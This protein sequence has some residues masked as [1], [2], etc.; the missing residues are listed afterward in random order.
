MR[1]NEG[2]E[3]DTA[4]RPREALESKRK[5]ERGEHTSATFARIPHVKS[6]FNEL[7]K[8]NAKKGWVRS[9]QIPDIFEAAQKKASKSVGR[10]VRGRIV[11]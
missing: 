5:R 1:E 7:V 4:R 3:R 8:Q 9:Q 11:S 10:K 6:G 2:Q